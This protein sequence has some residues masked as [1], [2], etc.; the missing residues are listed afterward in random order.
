[1]NLTFFRILRILRIGRISR[2][3]RVLKVFKELRVLVNSILGSVRSLC[4]TILLL[5][6]FMYVQSIFVTQLVADY[7]KE[8]SISEVDEDHALDLENMTR[9]FGSVASTLYTLFK[10]MSSGVDWGDVAQ[11]LEDRIHILF[12]PFFCVYIAFGVFAVLNVVTGV[13]VNEATLMSS[14]DQ[15]LIIEEELSRSDSHVNEFI[16]MF[17]EADTDGSGTVS[18]DEFTSHIEDDRVK[19]YFKVLDLHLDQAEQLF[20][21]LDPHKTGEVSIDDFVKGCIRLKGG[22]KSID[23][24]TLVHQNKAILEDI[25]EM[26]NRLY[27]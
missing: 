25:Q 5:I 22:A 16:R 1:M 23:I 17:H 20:V 27:R 10:A 6:V 24:Q 13:F 4:W 12:A 7:R 2:L 11:P 9:M 8:F 26:K 18:W 15:E 14:K 3:V 19:A 21:L